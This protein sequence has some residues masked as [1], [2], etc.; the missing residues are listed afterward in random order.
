MERTEARKYI[1]TLSALLGVAHSL[2]MMDVDNLF[3][4]LAPQS[5]HHQRS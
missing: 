3:I 4:G 1:A 5:L 2:W